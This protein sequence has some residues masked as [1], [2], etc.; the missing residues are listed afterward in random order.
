MDLRKRT[1]VKVEFIGDNDM[2]VWLELDTQKRNWASRN[3][4]SELVATTRKRLMKKSPTR[5]DAF[6]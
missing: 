5:K 2:H 4:C 3:Q 6:A 1:P